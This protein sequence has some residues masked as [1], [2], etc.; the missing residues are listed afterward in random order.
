MPDQFTVTSGTV[1]FR[2]FNHPNGSARTTATLPMEV[3]K[4]GNST[5]AHSSSTKILT[6]QGRIFWLR[7]MAGSEQAAHSNL[8]TVACE[9]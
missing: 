4:L 8:E 5:A 6:I 9:T 3:A 7:F 1:R 2:K